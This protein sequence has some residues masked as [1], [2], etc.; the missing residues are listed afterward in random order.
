[1]PYKDSE[2]VDSSRM[3]DPYWIAMSRHAQFVRKFLSHHVFIPLFEELPSNP[4]TT[5]LLQAKGYKVLD[6]DSE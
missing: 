5:N 4:D 3:P 6:K 1:V 2:Q